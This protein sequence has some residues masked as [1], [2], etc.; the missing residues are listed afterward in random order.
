MSAHSGLLGK[1]KRLR[2]LCLALNLRL[3]KTVSEQSYEE[4]GRN[5]GFVS[6]DRLAVDSHEKLAI[7]MDFALHYPG[8]DGQSPV[9]RFLETSPPSDPEEMA[10]LR[11]MISSYYSIFQITDLEQGIGIA[12]TDILRNETA[13]VADV[14]FGTT[15]VRNSFFAARMIATDDFLLTSGS[16]VFL[17]ARAMRQVA[18]D[19]A[20]SGQNPK[21]FDFRQITSAQQAE[22]AATAIRASFSSGAMS[23]V[24]YVTPEGTGR[25]PEPPVRVSR[26]GRNDRCPCGSGKKFKL[27]CG[28]N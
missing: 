26:P 27:C 5:L 11:G 14:G 8:P 22:L 7:L 10:A 21:E 2:A 3:V 12:V 6:E 1:Y 13:F 15:G 24:K 28:R 16:V 25:G 4:C 23:H 9:A 18:D 19:L 20:R 17:D